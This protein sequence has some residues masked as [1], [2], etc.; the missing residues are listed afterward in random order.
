MSQCHTAAPPTLHPPCRR[1]INLLEAGII[2]YRQSLALPLNQ[3]CPLDLR[4]KER[5]LRNNDLLTTYK[6]IGSGFAAGII[7]FCAEF[8]MQRW[9]KKRALRRA[10]SAQR[11]VRVRPGL[12][13]GPRAWRG[14]RVWSDRIGVAID[15]AADSSIGANS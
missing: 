10:A 12:G 7:A 2:K 4:S 8:L 11:K 15:G 1:L 6:V 3:I 14:V 9:R 13:L 5:Q